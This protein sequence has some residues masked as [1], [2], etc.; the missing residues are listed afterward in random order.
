MNTMTAQSLKQPS[1]THTSTT[2]NGNHTATAAVGV[3]PSTNTVPS[4]LQIRFR[5]MILNHGTGLLAELGAST[6][7][8]FRTRLT[9]MLILGP[10]AVLADF[11]GAVSDTIGFVLAGLALIPC[12]ER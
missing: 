12:A 2:T 11:S 8:V 5:R 7:V 10:I 4:A 6:E 1:S 3:S 9:W